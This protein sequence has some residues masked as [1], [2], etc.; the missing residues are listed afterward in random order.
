VH[1]KLPALS[2]MFFLFF[3]GYPAAPHARVGAQQFRD[4]FADASLE[5]IRV[6][7]VSQDNLEREIHRIPD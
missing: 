6:C 4:V 2:A 1:L 3:D 5:C 7:K